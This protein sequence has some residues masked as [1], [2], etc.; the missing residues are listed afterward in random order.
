MNSSSSL[1]RE[2]E[3]ENENER[4]AIFR[5]GRKR[6][7]QRRNA[8]KS[9]PLTLKTP[10]NYYGIAT[11]RRGVFISRKRVCL[12]H[13]TTTKKLVPSSKRA[14]LQRERTTP[15]RRKRRKKMQKE[16]PASVR[17]PDFQIFATLF[18]PLLSLRPSRLLVV[19]SLF[20]NT[21]H[22]P[23]PIRSS[24]SRALCSS[25]VSNARKRKK[26]RRNK[27]SVAIINTN[28]NNNN[29]NKV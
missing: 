4:A 27:S 13:K 16:E 6:K 29:N 20:S 22:L 28:N 11:K 3:N 14:E 23:T 12:M 15:S 7:F 17:F 10:I 8:I 18:S 21:P 9:L 1:L 24:S 19:F 5:I 25:W 26:E 2:R